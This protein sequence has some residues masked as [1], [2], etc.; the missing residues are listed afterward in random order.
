MKYKFKLEIGENPKWFYI[1]VC[2]QYEEYKQ[3]LSRVYYGAGISGI[4]TTQ[5]KIQYIFPGGG[6]VC[7]EDVF[8]NAEDAY[9]ECLDRNR[10]F[11]KDKLK[12]HKTYLN[13][14]K[15]LE[16][17]KLCMGGKSEFDTEEDI[18]NKKEDMK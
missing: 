16:N 14:Y 9:K 18:G 12:I 6:F 1:S 7:D 8:L 13:A 17:D 3:G 5:D 11:I 10:K 4:R 15:K 2:P